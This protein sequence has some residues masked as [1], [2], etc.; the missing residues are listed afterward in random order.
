MPNVPEMT[1]DVPA[2]KPSKPSV[3][4]APF[5]TAVTMNTVT[6]IYNTQV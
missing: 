5:D 1:A 6:R 2:A 4:L 3:M